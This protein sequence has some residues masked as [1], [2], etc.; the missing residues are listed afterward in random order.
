MLRRSVA[1]AKPLV[2]RPPI[3]PRVSDVNVPED[4]PLWQFFA[5][6]KYMRTS[7]ELNGVGN[8][9]T[10]PQLRRKSFDD[11]HTL[12]YVCLKEWNRLAREQY[13]V[14]QWMSRPSEDTFTDDNSLYTETVNKIR[15]SMWRIR[16]V[17]AERYHGYREAGQILGEEYPKL[18]AEFS[19]EYL[20]ADSNADAEVTGQLERFQFAFFGINP[21]LEGNFPEPQVLRGLYAVARL[22][23]ARYASEQSQVSDV[24]DVREAFLLFTCEHS[25]EGVA[26]AIESILEVRQAEPV[27][28]ELET[29][30]QLMLASQQA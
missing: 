5:D 7:T 6:Q 16:H 15:E 9:W 30:S 22:K 1:N 13:I 12:W 19:K 2:L 10:I 20:E 23:L 21:L 14:K 25:P 3:E 8:S 27:E 28:D 4:H 17:L 26:E 29:L 24:K 18:L 11:L